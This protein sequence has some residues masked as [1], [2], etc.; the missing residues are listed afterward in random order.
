MATISSLGLGSGL[1]AETIVSKLVALEKQPL[2]S[3][4]TKA[5]NT[6]SQ[7]SAFG[8]LKSEVS[9]L[10][11]AAAAML[12]SDAWST[13]TAVSSNTS[14]ATMTVTSSADATAFTLDVDALAKAQ[15]NTS[16]AL[17]ST[18]AVGAG[19][20]TLQ[21]GTWSSASGSNTFTAGSSSSVDVAIT[22]TDTIATMAAKINKANTGVVATVFNDG[23][24]NRLLL[25]SKETGEAA[26]FRVQAKDSNGATITS[27]TD[28]G[29]FAFDPAAGAFGM[30]GS[31][32]SVTYGADAKARINGLAVTSKTNTLTD[33][34][35][36]VT[37]NLL[38]TT[39]TNYGQSN[40]TKSSATL[41]I[42]EDVTPAVRSIQK[43]VDAYNKLATDLSD[44]TRYD[45]D[46]KAAGLFQGDSVI[47]GLQTVL[48]GMIGSTGTGS[49]T[50]TR[51]SDV[52]VQL[53]PDGTTL[54]LNTSKLATAANNGTELRKMFVTDT[55]NAQTQ[56]FALKF[57]NFGKRSIEPVGRT[58]AM[59]RKEQALNAILKNNTTEQTRINT[60][61]TD[62]ETRLRRQYSALD[63]KMAGMSSLSAYVTQQVAQW[64]KS[65]S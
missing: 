45:K 47:V 2:T 53:N 39:T 46:T 36:G 43:F 49:S 63:A 24:N 6:Q 48:R 11:D 17:S 28:L 55:G 33:T 40:E 7:I 18:A 56:G 51:L 9:A 23:T 35:P 1:D 19:T 20:L 62:V 60:R 10:A 26:G 52:G 31:A 41:T 13:R 58:G 8:Q 16:A 42:K 4:Q 25:R 64:N 15:S 65:S 61:A 44:L 54:T 5:K 57:Q 34:V 38:S 22:S 14:A 59:D 12:A 27:D 30:A 29:R 37:I 3:L 21:L 32:Q 50:Y